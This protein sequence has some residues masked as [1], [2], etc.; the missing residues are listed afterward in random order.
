V[1]AE[2]RRRSHDPRPAILERY[3]SKEDYLARYG[4]A[5]DALIAARFVLPE[6]RATLLTRG[7]EEWRAATAGRPD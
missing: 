2:E 5:V 7:E 6:D 1:T 4:R 3:A